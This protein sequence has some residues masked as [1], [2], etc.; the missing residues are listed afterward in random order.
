VQKMTMNSKNIQM[1]KDDR[2]FLCSEPLTP[3]ETS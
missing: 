2:I 1:C 3:K